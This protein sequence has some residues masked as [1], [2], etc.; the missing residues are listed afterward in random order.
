MSK[1]RSEVPASRSWTFQWT[2]QTITKGTRNETK[3]ESVEGSRWAEAIAAK[4]R[5]RVLM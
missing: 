4:P 3:Q 2:A 5:Q 1:A